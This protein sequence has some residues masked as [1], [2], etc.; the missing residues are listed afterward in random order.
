MTANQEIENRVIAKIRRRRAIG[1]VKYGTTM[2]REDLTFEEWCEHLQGEL[3]DCAIYTEK[4]MPAVREG[5][6]AA[7]RDIDA[8]DKMIEIKISYDTDPEAALNNCRFWAPLSLTAEQKH[9]VSDPIEMERL[10]D[11]LPIEQ[12]ARRWIVSS[13]PDEAV[14]KVADY[15]KYG[16]NHLVFHA[17]GH[18]QRRFL[19]LF[20]RDL[21]P[22]LRKLG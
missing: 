4:L 20:E 22:R 16:L 14:E 13:D 19:E 7:D 5:A 18:D 11:E 3:I 15:L 8:I 21:A 1:R 17:P 10:A 2:E 6:A 12:V 9:S